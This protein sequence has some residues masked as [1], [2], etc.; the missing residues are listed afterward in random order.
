[1]QPSILTLGARRIRFLNLAIRTASRSTHH[2][3][4][5]AL[6][7]KGNKLLSKG[8]N[9]M[10]THPKAQTA[11]QRIHA[12]LD[13]LLHMTSDETRGAT[14]IVVRLTKTGLLAMSRPCS[15][16]YSMLQLAGFKSVVYST[17]ERVVIEERIVYGN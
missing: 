14:M 11:W 9:Q 3:R 15:V 16:C 5:G 10:R 6:I 1:V 8:Y 2:M 7:V 12:E 13:A 17:G 4:V